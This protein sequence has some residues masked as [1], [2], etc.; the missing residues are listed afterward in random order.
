MDPRFP[1]YT[2]IPHPQRFP[3]VL[4]DGVADTLFNRLF[5]QAGGVPETSAATEALLTAA[6]FPLGTRTLLEQ[7]LD[8]LI[9]QHGGVDWPE[10]GCVILGTA[11]PEM[12]QNDEGVVIFHIPDTTVGVR[13]FPGDMHPRDGM[14]F[15]DL[16]DVDKRRPVNTPAA[17]TF[18]MI[19]PRSD[20]ALHSMEEYAGIR[21][22]DI[23][24]GEE[25]YSIPEGD[26]CR[27]KRK[28]AA[29]FLFRIPVHPKVDNFI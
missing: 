23:K 27:L 17:Y 22:E 14:F 16:Y 12:L 6:K 10:S 20:K 3:D 24:P 11:K 18:W 8:D 28:G 19:W 21:R 2:P 7:Q 9:M 26:A 5:I 15:F 4:P 25:R 29:D 13:V 1:N